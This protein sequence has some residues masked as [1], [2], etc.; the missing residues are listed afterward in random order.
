MGSLRRPPPRELVTPK[1]PTPQYDHG[2][3]IVADAPRGET[4]GLQRRPD[5]VYLPRSAS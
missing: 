5:P 3:R 2:V 1:R 4:V